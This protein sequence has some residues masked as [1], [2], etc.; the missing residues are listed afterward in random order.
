MSADLAP[1]HW[2]FSF[3][4]K[5]EL[6]ACCYWEYARESAFIC[7][8]LTEMRAETWQAVAEGHPVD[9][10]PPAGWC[11]RLARLRT[12]G[13]PEE[14]FVRGCLKTPGSAFQSTDPDRADYRDPDGPTL[15]GSF[16][17]PWQTLA[18]EERQCRAEICAG[19]QA[20]P[21]VPLRLGQ[22]HDARELV[23][24][25]EAA[26]QQQ[27]T[28]WQAW[29]RLWM[30]CDEHGHYYAFP[31]APEPPLAAEFRPGLLREGVEA[32]LVDIDWSHFT[33]EQLTQAFR[34][35]VQ[36]ARPPELTAPS[37]KGHKPGD[38]QTKLTRLGV[39]RLLAG[40]SALDIVDDRQKRFAQI[41]Q[42]PQ[43]AGDQWADVAKW[44]A[45]RRAAGQVFRALFPFLP[46]GEK[47][48][49]WT[50]PPTAK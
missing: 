18:P 13:G 34:Q 44:H 36:A 49:S 21:V 15:S 23:Q 47:P 10:H 26:V 25:C 24:A 46:A 20:Y 45:A 7:D 5:A 48:R 17:A 4:P 32:L 12:L 37:G 2:D 28:A 40:A 8:T 38:W 43:F 3:V 1:Q 11:E 14:V 33:N 16:P 31:S 27:S 35:W 42:A 30:R 29:A 6:V 9:Q 22:W 50:R 41:W 39:L 19:A